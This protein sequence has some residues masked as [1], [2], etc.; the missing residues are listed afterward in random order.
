MNVNLSGR[1]GPRGRYFCVVH[2]SSVSHSKLI[3]T[4]IAQKFLIDIKYCGRL[5][6]SVEFKL[7]S[8]GEKMSE[9]LFQR[10]YIQTNGR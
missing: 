6:K 2:E 9:N 7:I 3:V 10:K 1:I 8:R 4:L 5:L